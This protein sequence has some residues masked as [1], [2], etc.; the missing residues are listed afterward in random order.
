MATIAFIGL[1]NMGLPM[2]TR[3]CQAE[4]Q[5]RAVD[6]NP[7]ATRRA[8][9]L[10]MQI[11]DSV[12]TAVAGAQFVI[13]MLPSGKHVLDTLV[14]AAVEY[15]PGAVVIDSSTI[16]VASCGALHAALSARGITTLDAPVSGGVG[17]AAAGTLTFM[18]GGSEAAFA[19]A[20]PVLKLM[21]KNIIHAGDAGAGQAAKIC[22]NMI[23]GIS[24]VAVSEALNL[25]KR[26]GLD[27]QKF[28]DIASTSSGQCWALTS[29]S[30]EPGLVPTSPSNRGYE[31][32]FASELMLKDLRLAEQAAMH[33]GSPA[34]LGAAAAAMYAMHCK[35]GK[36]RLDF[37]SIMQ[38]L[39]EPVPQSRV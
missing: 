17:G 20:L 30:P 5:V 31:G 12:K 21:G 14:H 8:A 3:L 28:F 16:D 19:Q 7:Q 22:N 38:M 39:N 1:G 27:P 15:A 35:A 29:Y 13:T 25:A 26:L 2:A 4:H 10:G 23:T 34:L 18:V 24:M 32:G 6:P 36:G 11:D 37:S 9:E 33:S